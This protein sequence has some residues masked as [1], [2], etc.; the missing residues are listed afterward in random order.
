M[1]KFG[2]DPSQRK[3]QGDVCSVDL[4]RLEKVILGKQQ[5]PAVVVA[6]GEILVHIISQTLLD[7]F[8]PL[9]PTKKWRLCYLQKLLLFCYFLAPQPEIYMLTLVYFLRVKNLHLHC[10]AAVRQVT[11]IRKGGDVWMAADRPISSGISRTAARTCLEVAWVVTTA[12][13]NLP[14]LAQSEHKGGFT[15]FDKT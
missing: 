1:A 6:L 5:L 13:P 7:L 2:G 4:R 15:I 10:R 3:P 12:W 9:T 8:T 11:L 14:K